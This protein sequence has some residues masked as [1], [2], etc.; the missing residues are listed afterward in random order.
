[1]RGFDESHARAYALGYYHGRAVGNDEGNPF[2]D[3]ETKHLYRMGY[4][5]GV[6]DYCEEEEFPTDESRAFGPHG[7]NLWVK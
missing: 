1:M 5:A 2:E 7:G 4:D 3:D 6:A